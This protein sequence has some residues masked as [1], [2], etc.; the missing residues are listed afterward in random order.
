MEL[1]LACYMS[2]ESQ[3][4]PSVLAIHGIKLL[5][6]GSIFHLYNYLLSIYYI[7]NTAVVPEYKDE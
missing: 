2:Q 5:P 7:P 1:K 3:L 4:L 6:T